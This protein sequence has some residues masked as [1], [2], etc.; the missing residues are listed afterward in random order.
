M[1]IT[2]RV[3]NFLA[4]LVIFMCGALLVLFPEE[5]FGVVALILG[6][7]LLV[8]GIRMTVFYF[9]MAR[10]MVGGRY[11]LYIGVIVIDFGMF[12]LGMSDMPRFYLSLYLIF[13][14][15]FSGFVDIMRSLEAKQ[16]GASWKLNMIHGIMN[17]LVAVL[18]LI[19]LNSTDMLVTLYGCGLIASACM[20]MA[21]TFRRTAIVYIQ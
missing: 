9:R 19:Y 4:G 18:C 21:K 12:T 3:F 16:Y 5:S 10:H 7:S 6:V 13:I 11:M 1:T 2:Q 14:Y 20:R 15:A 8:S 17:V